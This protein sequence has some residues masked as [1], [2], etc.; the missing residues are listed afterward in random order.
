MH[1][2]A[3][4]VSRAV[5][6]MLTFNI[7]TTN[8]GSRRLWLPPLVAITT[9][10][11]PEF[12][13]IANPKRGR[14]ANSQ[15]S[16]PRGSPLAAHLLLPALPSQTVGPP[17]PVFSPDRRQILFAWNEWTVVRANRRHRP[18]RH[19]HATNP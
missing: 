12:A 1:A 2:N 5:V 10:A 9:S 19:S 6:K 7:E 13:A 15:P 3:T 8:T 14:Q 18:D 11:K 4:N 17:A 16:L